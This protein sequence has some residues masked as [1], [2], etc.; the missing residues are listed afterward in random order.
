ML[1]V[2]LEEKPSFLEPECFRDRIRVPHCGHPYFTIRDPANE[3]FDPRLSCGLACQGGVAVVN[4][5]TRNK[6]PIPGGSN[7]FIFRSIEISVQCPITQ[8][9]TEGILGIGL[10]P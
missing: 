9:E 5:Y 3:R 6:I 2:P 1:H 7:I 10:R 4:R 8:M